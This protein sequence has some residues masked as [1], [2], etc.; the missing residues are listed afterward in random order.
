MFPR[1]AEPNVAD[2]RE[3]DADAFRNSSPCFGRSANFA[4]HFICQLCSI[5]PFTC[6]SGAALGD[7]VSHIVKLGA[8]KQ[9]GDIHAAAIITVM[10]DL[11]AGRNGTV[12]DFPCR[13]MRQDWAASS[14]IADLSVLAVHG[15]DPE[16]AFIRTRWKDIA[17]ESFCEWRKLGHSLR[18]PFSRL[19]RAI[20]VLI[21]P[22]W[23]ADY[24][25][26][27]ADTY[28]GTH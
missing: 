22:Q 17:G 24:T 18:D 23:P 1:F 21:T 4:N 8:K 19:V 26:L 14:V 2:S 20:S 6:M 11:Q 9:V 10:K 28:T 5:M 3:M 7:H 27:L 25:P 12:R 13:P 15:S 16:P